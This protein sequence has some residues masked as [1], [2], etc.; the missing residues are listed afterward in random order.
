MAEFRTP[1]GALTERV[2]RALLG[3]PTSLIVDNNVVRFGEI[4]VNIV[5]GKF[6][7]FEEEKSG[8]RNDLVRLVKPEL[9]NGDAEAWIKANV[10]DAAPEALPQELAA[11]RALLGLLALQP[12]LF[13]HVEE[14]ASADM[15]LSEI[16][17]RMFTAIAD[18]AAS[19][20]QQ[21]LTPATLVQAC[22][23]DK[24]APVFGRPLLGYIAELIAD[25]PM[26]PDAAHLARSLAVQ[27]RSHA[28]A[29]AGIE[30]DY[31][32]DPAPP[33][34]VPKFRGVRFENIDVQSGPSHE[35]VVDDWFTKGGR[36]VVGGA[37]LSGKSFFAI[38]TACC[39]ATGLPFFGNKIIL[40]G[41]VVYQAGEGE[42]GIRLR[43]KAWR[44]YHG[45]DPKQPVP[46]YIIE[47]KIDIFNPN[48]DTQ[49]FIDEIRGIAAT[50][51][52]PLR[53][54]F[55]DTLAKASIGAD[56][57]SGKDMGMVMGN[58]DRIGE[59]FP[60][61][62]ITL[63]HHMNAGGT[64]L[65]GHTS[66]YANADQVVL[67]AKN[68]DGET[69]TATLDKQKD[70]ESGLKIGF[71][72]HVV[73]VGRRQIDG[74]AITSCVAVPTTA[75]L[76]VAGS[77]SK[78]ERTVNLSD[79]NA[80]I[81]DALKK[82]LEQHGVKTPPALAAVL[83][84]SIKVVVEYKYW[85]EAFKALAFGKSDAAV[86]QAMARA[87]AK[88]LRLRIIGRDNPYV[89]L[90]G[91]SFTEAPAAMQGGSGATSTVQPDLIDDP[92]DFSPR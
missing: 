90:T 25:S 49:A 44:D 53:A 22:G 80:N 21:P 48:A 15:F 64:K 91:R 46:I 32:L 86:R 66:V 76:Q 6:Y 40:P 34:W 13:V 2:A 43:F 54:V 85:T 35:Y 11:E 88:F 65:R 92:L 63:V 79:Q 30:D 41:L 60:D 57:N 33:P 12:D 9:K 24:L 67:V 27:V 45:I 36:S 47:Q 8:D 74:K 69:S 78:K 19:D 73:E 72:L 75:A 7:D 26:A 42:T 56:E 28:N 61:V 16:H 50:Y 70:G 62:N 38:H 82:A 20:T 3:A 87:G 89:W 14:E 39:I 1:E 37:S 52:V 23:G 29:E 4:G 31:D 68:E 71:D 17:G 83:P 51:S 59:A 10:L 77:G 84:P 81:L 58:L 18:A 5:S 55:I